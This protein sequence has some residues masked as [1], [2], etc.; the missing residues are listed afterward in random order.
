[1]SATFRNREAGPL[2][3][4]LPL[5]VDMDFAAQ[6]V[7]GIHRYLGRALKASV[8]RRSRHWQ[9]DYSSHERYNAS[10]EKNRNRFRQI[11]GVVD[12]RVRADFQ[13]VAENPPSAS[14]D[15]CLG[16]GPGYRTHAVRWTVLTGVEG[17][18]LLLIPSGCPKANVIALPDCDWTPEMLTGHS[19]GIPP[20][21]QFAR[22][23]AENGC[24]VLIPVLIDRKNDYSGVPW[25]AMTNQPH[26]EFIYRTAFP[27]GRHIIGYEVQKILAAVDWFARQND[28]PRSTGVIGYGEGGL[29]ALYSAAADT[30]IDAVAVCGYFRQREGI[31]QEPIYRN[32]FGLLEQFGDAELVSLIAPR[33]VCIE[34]CPHPRVD[35]PPPGTDSRSGAASGALTTPR[36]EEVEAEFQRACA[37]V[38]PLKPAPRLT[39]VKNTGGQP[40]SDRLLQDFLNDLTGSHQL[41]PSKEKPESHYGSVDSSAR[42]E[43]Q[44]TQLLNHTRQLLA[45]AEFHRKDF[46]V[47]REAM[48]KRVGSRVRRRYDH[49]PRKWPPG[50]V[51]N[52]EA[53]EQK[54]RWYRDYYWKEILGRL[55]APRLPSNPRTRQIYDEPAYRGYEVMLDVYPDVFTYGILLVPKG[56]PEGERRPVVVCQHGLEGTPRNVADLEVH[57]PCYNQ[58]ACRLAE[59]GFITYAPQNP[60]RGG[61]N[62]RILQRLANPLKLTLFS[63]IVR[64]HERTLEWLATLPF[65]DSAR[66][67]FYGLS[68]GGMTAMRVPAILQQ[69]CLSICSAHYSDWLRK[70]A[71]IDSPYT[72]LYSVEWEMPEF[73]IGQTFNY[74]ELSWLICPRPFMVERGHEDPVGP[75]EWI[76]GEYAKTRQPYVLLGLDDRTEIEYFVDGHT[77][78]GEGTFRF[79]ERHLRWPE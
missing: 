74:A 76:A 35:G 43:R 25:L 28:G 64:Q 16:E 33:P 78:N 77:I 60:Y 1:M 45:E 66:V 63:F 75:D 30:R 18:G 3:D 37:F 13:Y 8:R 19:S 9:R 56:I 44:F 38:A 22:R 57:D 32:V 6:M 52:S 65:V 69:Y 49:I 31:W 12:E 58:Y 21:A 51:R 26:R 29:L 54:N 72:Y 71:S 23:L 53:W 42:M 47:T 39:L 48:H 46:W 7:S 73:N 41:E 79:L 10:I 17:E 34:D 50:D 70:V 67:A 11:I 40:G 4:T 5:S 55:P 36:C 27:L 61:D 68:Y 15:L 62:F 59:R 2:P 14:P 24:R 20:Q